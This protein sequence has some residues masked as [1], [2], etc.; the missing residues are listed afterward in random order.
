MENFKILEEK[1][2]PLFNRKEIQASIEAE[3]TP[4]RVDT[5]KLISEKF[6][7]EIENIKIK[8]ILGKFGSKTFTITANIYITKEDKEK[9][10]PEKAGKKVEKQEETQESPEEKPVEKTEVQESPE[11]PEESPKPQPIE[12][13][14]KEKDINKQNPQE[15]IDNKSEQPKE[16]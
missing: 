11:K 6:S 9:I 8:R 12:E 1:E 15:N 14:P 13:P 3:I 7:T 4:N 5:K 10:E 16:E 2:N